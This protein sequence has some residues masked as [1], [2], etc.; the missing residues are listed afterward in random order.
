MRKVVK[1]MLQT[2][3]MVCLHTNNMTSVWV[4]TFCCQFWKAKPAANSSNQITQKSDSLFM[5]VFKSK[6]SSFDRIT[7]THHCDD[8]ILPPPPPFPAFIYISSV[9]KV[10]QRYWNNLSRWYTGNWFLTPSK[11][12]WLHQGKLNSWIG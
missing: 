1:Y 7:S 11:P 6:S 12:W 2:T 3:A 4:R 5:L 8:E 9:K 10:V